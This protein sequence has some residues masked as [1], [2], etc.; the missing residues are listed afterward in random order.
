[1]ISG[2]ERTL[3]TAGFVFVGAV[4]KAAILSAIL[5]MGLWAQEGESDVGE[6]GL[7]TGIALGRTGTNVALSGGIGTSIDRYLILMVE[8]AYIPMGNKTF[9]P[10]PGVVAQSS[11]LYDFSIPLQIR[12]PIRRKWEPYGIIAPVLIY[13]HYRRLGIHP[14]GSAYYFGAS[15]VRG[16]AEAGGGVRYYLHEYWGLKGE[17][18][19]TISSRNFSSL[20]I[21]VFRQF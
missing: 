12:V 5:A 19:Y 15:D 1:M 3:S 11:G 10:Y 2:K 8:G 13:N 14:D 17:F 4:V 9:I 16:G 6:A 21:G 20:L 18:R 7:S